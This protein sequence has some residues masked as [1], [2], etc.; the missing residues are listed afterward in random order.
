ML[1]RARRRVT[2]LSYAVLVAAAASLAIGTPFAGATT[3][4]APVTPESNTTCTGSL[5]TD[6]SGSSV[7]EPDLL[8]YS[9]SCDTAISAYTI[10]VDRISG[11]DFNLD[12]FNGSPVVYETDDATPSPTE[13][14]GC[15]GTIPSS[16]INCNLGAGGSLTASYFVSGSVDPT[17]AYCKYLPSGAKP[18][19]P[20]VPQAIV[21]LIVTDDTGAEDGPFDLTPA[22][23]CPK[24]PNVVPAK[25]AK[26]NKKSGT[27]KKGKKADN[28]GSKGSKGS[29]RVPR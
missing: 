12:D 17:S 19:T 14:V 15:V 5:S 27:A 9:F 29:K 3:T 26:K 11:Q 13:T 24:V 21:Q 4:P 8:D 10:I 1:A 7:G 25:P 22:K 18:G 2:T 6:P 20:A 16:G 28:K 23:A